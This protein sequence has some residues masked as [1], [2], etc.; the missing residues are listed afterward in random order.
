[1]TRLAEIIALFHALV[2]LCAGWIWGA[3]SGVASGIGFSLAGC[4]LGLVTGFLVSRLPR[5]CGL[6]RQSI[7]PKFR[8]LAFLFAICGFVAGVA[9]WLACINCV[10][11]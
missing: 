4:A 8:F 10:R 3:R 6:I 2:G 1:M 11:E 7:A 5:A 9:F